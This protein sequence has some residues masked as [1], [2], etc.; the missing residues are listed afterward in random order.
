[1]ALF[2]ARA[3]VLA[4]ACLMALPAL[5]VDHDLRAQ[6]F[7]RDVARIGLMACRTGVGALLDFSRLVMANRTIDPGRLE[8]VGMR[9]SQLLR[10]DLMVTLDAFDREILGVHLVVKHHF[11]DRR[12]ENSFGR[13]LHA[14]GHCRYADGSKKDSR[15][16][17]SEVS[18]H[19]GLVLVA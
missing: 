12:G 18:D 14:V 8:I 1:M 10:I 3:C 6:R 2:A 11:T 13:P 5:L 15:Y 16:H 17:S 19:G 7:I 9:S 4:F